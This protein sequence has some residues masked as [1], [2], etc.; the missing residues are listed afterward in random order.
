MEQEVLSDKKLLLAARTPEQLEEILR[1]KRSLSLNLKR[2]LPATPGDGRSFSSCDVSEDFSSDQMLP[3]MSPQENDDSTATRNGSSEPDENHNRKRKIAAALNL[4]YP[5]LTSNSL[6]TA[7]TFH[8][9]A[10]DSPDKR[11]QF[12]EEDEEE[13]EE[14]KDKFEEEEEILEEADEEEEQNNSKSDN[15]M[16]FKT[17]VDEIRVFQRE[18]TP[19]PKACVNGCTD[20]VSTSE[21]SVILQDSL[22]VRA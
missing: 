10:A 21:T 18:C 2:A 1:R 12:D 5:E 19:E 14:A 6:E 9:A 17:S 11:L 15:D 7:D 3:A 20:S 16:D 4:V 13:E 8:T 22:E